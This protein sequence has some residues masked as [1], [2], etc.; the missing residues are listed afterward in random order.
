MQSQYKVVLR[1][2]FIIQL[3]LLLS[4]CS[5]FMKKES[6]S[7]VKPTIKT[8]TEKQNLWKLR[9]RSL[10][11]KH[12]WSLDARAGLNYQNEPTSFGLFWQ[13]KDKAIFLLDIKN[14]FTGAVVA[15]LNQ[16]LN[17]VS[18]KTSNG[19]VYKANNAETLLEEQT[20]MSLP[21]LGMQ[22]WI[23]GLSSKKYS[24]ELLEL[25]ALGRPLKMKQAG[26]DINY[27]SY[28]NDTALSLPRKI[29]ISRADE[30]D[31][32]IKLLIKAWQSL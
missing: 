6:V 25:D 4:A 31:I 9:Q 22:S 3:V 20:G 29:K 15:S 17:T 16:G 1:R 13:Q 28:L 26:W 23:K 24:V 10:E 14:P 11:T 2:L 7:S 27:T 18:L 12:Q 32:Q 19:A 5:N 8:P 30:K 21:I